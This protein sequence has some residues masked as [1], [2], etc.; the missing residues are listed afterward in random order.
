MDVTFVVAQGDTGTIGRIVAGVSE[1][2]GEASIFAWIESTIVVALRVVNVDE[3][4]RDV[5]GKH[6]DFVCL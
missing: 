5:W 1:A 4:S 6:F 3:L 2:E